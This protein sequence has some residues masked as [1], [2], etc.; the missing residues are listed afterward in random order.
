MKPTSIALI[1]G[2]GIAGR[3]LS[4][5]LKKA[6]ISSTVYEAYPYTQGVGGGLNLAPNGM[7]VLD[8]LGL[9]RMSRRALPRPWR[10]VEAKAD[11]SWRESTMAA[12]SMASL[13]STCDEPTYMRFLYRSRS[14]TESQSKYEKLSLRKTPSDHF[15]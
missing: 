15:K 7:N 13:R 3:A 14:N 2:G 6:G 10:T 4:L 8:E 11:E 1:I 12:R 9:A 5:F